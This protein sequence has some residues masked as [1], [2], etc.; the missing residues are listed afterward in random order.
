MRTSGGGGVEGWIAA[1]PI[2]ALIIVASMSAGGPDA[3]LSTLNDIL[4][5]IMASVADLVRG[6][7]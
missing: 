4:R 5:T 6:L 2:F 7:F 1:I 3:M